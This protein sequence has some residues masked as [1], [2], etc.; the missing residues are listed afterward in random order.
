MALSEVLYHI[1]AGPIENKS[2]PGPQQTSLLRRGFDS[3][4]SILFFVVVL[5]V[6]FFD[7][8]ISAC[9]AGRIPDEIQAP[10]VPF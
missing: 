7:N 5:N 9:T 4:Q 10:A 8:M 1:Q 3:L 6:I 2:I